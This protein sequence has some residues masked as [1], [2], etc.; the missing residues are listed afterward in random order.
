[1]NYPTTAQTSAQ[2]ESLARRIAPTVALVI[3][4]VIV[5]YNAGYAMGRA[6]H[7]ANDYLAQ[8]WPTRPTS[9]AEPQP[10]PAPAPLQEIIRTTGTVVLLTQAE[11]IEQARA[12]RAQGLTQRAI[13]IRMGVSRATVRRRLAAV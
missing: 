7:Q 1:M 12:L 6:I 9:T 11:E 8:N 3:T 4:A 13:A 5:T 2:L 10:A